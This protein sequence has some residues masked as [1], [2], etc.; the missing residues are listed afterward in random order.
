MRAIVYEKYG[1]PEVLELREIEK[2]IPKANE[3]LIRIHAVTVTKGDCEIRSPQIPSLIW[4]ILRLF[5]GFVRPR[6]KI[7]GAYTSGEIEAVGAD[8]TLFKP[9]DQVFACTGAHFSAY[10]EY[11]CMAETE[12]LVLKPANIS[13]EEAA[14]VPLALDAL[15][16]FSKADVQSGETVLINGAGGSIGTFAVQLAKYFGA[17]AVAVDSGD[18]LD[19]L[20][21]IGADRVIDYTTEGY[22]T[23]A[24][25]VIFNLVSTSPFGR[26]MRL[27]KRNGRYLLV[28][29]KG[30]LQILRGA[31]AS[32]IGSNGR[33]VI[34]EFADARSE[35]LRTLKELVE[36]GR[37][38]SY[39]DR[40]FPLEQ[41]VEA[42]RYI[43]AGHKRGNIVLT[44]V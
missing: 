33:R 29:P 36:A 14:A 1:P 9:G 16:F 37:L 19:M 43:E 30:V 28:N 11:V 31:L 2:P 35:Y 39:I 25:D 27:L 23:G 13:Y 5:F 15:H 20:R 8:V 34:Y 44:V 6:K 42:H 4:F 38:T 17:A 24:Y 40:S 21:S 26:N 10:A 7:L 32:M 41:A 18:K 12:A 3:V 22:A